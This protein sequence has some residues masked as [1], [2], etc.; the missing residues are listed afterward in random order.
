M[1]V[2]TLQF[3]KAAIYQALDIQPDH[4]IIAKKPITVCFPKQF[5]RA[6]LAEVYDVVNCVGIVGLISEGKYC[7]LGVLGRFN[8]TPAVI[9]E[10][11]V[12]GNMYVFM[13]FEP[14]ETVL[15]S[16]YIP[17]D[18]LIVYD[19]F[20]ECTKY[21]RIPWYLDFEK[22]LSI[23]DESV[24][25]VGTPTGSSAQVIR[26][27]YALTC[28]DPNNPDIAF[29]YSDSLNDPSVKPLVIGMN[30]PSQLLTGTFARYSGGYLSDNVI[31]G[32]LEG[33]SEVSQLEEILKGIP[34]E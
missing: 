26:V 24:G 5:E 8:F 23:I 7:C 32:L 18:A 34:N 6:G 1:D 9:A 14:G 11:L 4:S 33:Q 30:N 20:L 22:F 15:A 16:L 12:D 29:R 10:E 28:R 21:A 19:Y 27:I 31:A 3:D 17:I 13:H 2:S 25:I